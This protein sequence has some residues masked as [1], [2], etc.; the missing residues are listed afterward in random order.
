MR[1]TWPLFFL[2]VAAALAGTWIA[3]GCGSS[4]GKET[5]SDGGK[6]ASTADVVEEPDLDTGPDIN[7]NPNVYPSQHH[8]VPQLNYNGGPILTQPRVVTVTFVG[9]AHRDAFR[10]FD[11]LIVTSPWWQETAEGFCVDGGT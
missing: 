2:V 4:S 5:P 8:P 3:A 10:Q 11:H 9:D 6:D 7:Q 1:S